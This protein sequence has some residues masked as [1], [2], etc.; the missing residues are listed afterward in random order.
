MDTL[1][2]KV[3]SSAG[4]RET[5]SGLGFQSVSLY[6]VVTQSEAWAASRA[7]LCM[8]ELPESAGLERNVPA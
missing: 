1:S 6:P 8:V 5:S 4:L 3:P 2:P 7:W